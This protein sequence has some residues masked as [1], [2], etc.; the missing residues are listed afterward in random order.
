[1]TQEINAAIEPNR[2]TFVHRR[3]L[4]AFGLGQP[5]QTT[6]CIYTVLSVNLEVRDCAAYEGVGPALW[7]G[8]THD[9]LIKRIRA[10]GTTISENEAHK[11]FEEIENMEL[12]YRG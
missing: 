11:L 4:P 6:V 9:D 3:F 5:D 10:G 1:M 8:P 2:A 12:R 7:S